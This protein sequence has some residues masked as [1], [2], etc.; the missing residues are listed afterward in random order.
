MNVAA[1]LTV[2]ERFALILDMLCRAVAAQISGR[3]MTEVMILLVWRR[4]RRIDLR[5]QGM[6]RRFR[7]GRLQVRTEFCAVV[8]SGVGGKRGARGLPVMPR[9]FG[10]L[11]A[12]VPCEAA[13]YASQLRH[14]LAEPEMVALLAAAP[15]ARRLLAPLCRMLA[16]EP[17]VLVPAV[18]EA[19]AVV[20]ARWEEAKRFFFE[21][22]N[23]KTSSRLAP[24]SG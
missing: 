21:K 13:G 10:W 2:S 22:K 9:S 23:Q 7:D 5:L 20:V 12:L 16:I 1:T 18:T 15:Q 14:A 24:P 17:E 19:A 8:R 6:L 11:L 4:V 3:R